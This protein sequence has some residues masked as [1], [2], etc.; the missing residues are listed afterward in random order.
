M[1]YNYNIILNKVIDIY[2]FCVIMFISVR[3]LE[4][5]MGLHETIKSDEDQLLNLR[6]KLTN[7]QK[8]ISR[9]ENTINQKKEMLKKPNVSDHALLRFIERKLEIDIDVVRRGLLT[10]DVVSA[11]RLGCKSFKKDGMEIKIQ[12]CTVTTIL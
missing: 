9:M 1:S 8:E 4:N 7:L 12:G 3:K 6:V 11:M 10:D 2:A 5:Q